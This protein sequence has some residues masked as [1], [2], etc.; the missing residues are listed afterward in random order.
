MKKNVQQEACV[1]GK[2]GKP[3]S[4]YHQRLNEAAGDL[5]LNNKE[6]HKSGYTYAKGK[7]WSKVFTSSVERAPV[8]EKVDKEENIV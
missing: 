1:F 8:R 3:L 5:C 4:K 7:S 2:S 6:L